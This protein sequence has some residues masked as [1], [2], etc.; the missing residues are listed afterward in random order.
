MIDYRNLFNEFLTLQQLLVVQPTQ[1]PA[2]LARNATLNYHPS[3]EH[4]KTFSLC[5][6]SVCDAL[7]RV[8]TLVHVHISMRQYTM[9]GAS[10][11]HVRLQLIIDVRE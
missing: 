1:R 10:I 3:I 2:S 7:S 9:Y 6:P 4:R 5:A 8:Y 11:T